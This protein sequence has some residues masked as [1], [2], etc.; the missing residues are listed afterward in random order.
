[1]F[2]FY[3]C[4]QVL[5]G[6]SGYLAAKRSTLFSSQLLTLMLFPLSKNRCLFLAPSLM[7]PTMQMNRIKPDFFYLFLFIYS[8]ILFSLAFLF[9]FVAFDHKKKPNPC[10]SIESITRP[11]GHKVATRLRL[12]IASQIAEKHQKLKK[13]LQQQHKNPQLLKVIVTSVHLQECSFSFSQFFLWRLFRRIIYIYSFHCYF[14][15]HC[16]ACH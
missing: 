7:R 10:C 12:Q 11:K 2:H 8:N 6:I 13:P 9:L 5:E 3:C 15:P 14:F 16:C 1:M 4:L